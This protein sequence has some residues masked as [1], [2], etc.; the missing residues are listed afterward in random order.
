MRGPAANH[1]YRLPPP[2]FD[3]RCRACW[4][5]AGVLVL[6]VASFVSLDLPLAALFSSD[7]LASM[8]RFLA[9]FSSPDLS[10]AFVG[11]VTRATWE[12]LAMSLL[13]TLLATLAGG[14][15][16]LPASRL[17]DTDAAPAR[18]PARLML[19]ALRAV[20]ELV[21]AALLLIAVGLG[22]F[23]GT[24]ALAV[25]TTGVLGRL[26]AEAI[27][28]APPGPAA[29]LRVQGAGSVRVF[30]YATLPQVLPQLMSYTLYRWENNIRAAAV[31]GVV[32]AGGLGQMLAFHMGLF[33][34]HKT[35]TVLMAM[36]LL[37]AL[38]D[39]ASFGSRRLLTR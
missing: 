22:P 24:L 8:G 7:A 16:A 17:H 11:Q 21:W 5:C 20:P 37:V 32:G 1:R 15:L 33:Q 3:A 39:G 6:V 14:I 29:A 36:V 23:A 18:A 12:T 4:L 2:L 35:A 13:G 38:V 27:E 9:E 34:M 26:F 31:L 19:N 25:H 28:N 10:P 30:L